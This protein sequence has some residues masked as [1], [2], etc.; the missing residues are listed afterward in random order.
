M[1]KLLCLV[2]PQFL[3]AWG[4]RNEISILRQPIKFFREETIYAR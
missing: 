3:A 4:E 2:K 1:Q